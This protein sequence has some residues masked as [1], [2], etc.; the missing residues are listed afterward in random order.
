M[1]RTATTTNKPK[2]VFL[3]AGGAGMY[4]GSC[5]RDNTLVRHLTAQGWDIELVPAY[6]PIRTDE[7]DVSLD[8]VFFGGINLYLLQKLP[9]LGHLPGWL[10]R[11]LDHPALIRRATARASISVDA[12][13]LG[14]MALA[15]VEGSH[16]IL[17]REHERFV[18]WLVHESR[19]DLINLTNLLIGGSIPLLQQRLPNVPIVVTLQGDDLFL[20]QLIEP[21]KSQVISRMRGLA[22]QVDLFV[23]FTNSY[24]DAMAELFAVPRDRFRIVP[25]GIDPLEL[26]GGRP[27]RTGEPAAI[28]YFARICPEKGFQHAVAAFLRLAQMPGMDSVQFHFAG[29]RGEQDRA[30]F[31]RELA[32][33]REAGLSGRVH[34]HGSPDRQGKAAFFQGIDLFSVPAEFQEPKGLSVLEALSAGVPVVQPAHGSFPEMLSGCPAAW[35]VPPKNPS[36]LAQAWVDLLSRPD[37]GAALGALGPGF[38]R[39]QA[40][41]ER[42]ARETGAVYGALLEKR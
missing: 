33:L 14:A 9:V 40:S 26:P 29:W 1:P 10:F 6:T 37:R 5:M 2:V 22:A 38:V 27:S 34:D 31:D 3:T 32:R 21:W 42:M 4:C 39:E 18:D 28:G 20:S 15:T 8:R 35:L 12:R 23:T 24:A 16:G 7:A 17:R 11:W 13:E 19:P 41:A 36:A 30:F 25:L